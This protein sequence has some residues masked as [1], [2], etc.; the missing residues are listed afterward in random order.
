MASFSNRM[1]GAALLDVRTY[2]EV[3]ADVAGTTQAMLVVVLSSLATGIG[4]LSTEGV[5]DFVYVTLAALVGWFVWA[6]VTYLVGT[7]LLPEPE[8]RADVGQLLR[9]TGFSSAPGL[10]RVL[11][12]VPVIGPLIFFVTFFW[13]L[14]SFVVAVRQALD[15][16]STGRAIGVC[17]IGWLVYVAFSVA[18]WFLRNFIA[19]LS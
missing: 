8:T 2:E 13:M 10:L 5:L 9:T 18:A 12:I 11:G 1:L 7:K 15:Y 14:A 3:E 6:F 19:M 16:R 17:V 4:S